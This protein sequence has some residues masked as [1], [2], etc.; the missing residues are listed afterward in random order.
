MVRSVQAVGY[1]IRDLNLIPLNTGE[2]SVTIVIFFAAVTQQNLPP[3]STPCH[4][5]TTNC[6]TQR[7]NE[8]KGKCGELSLLPPRELHISLSV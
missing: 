8:T 5:H 7:L 3:A 6:N 2:T 4:K 1:T